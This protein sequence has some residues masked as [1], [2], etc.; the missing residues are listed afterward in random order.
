VILAR[1]EKLAMRGMAKTATNAKIATTAMNST[2]VKPCRLIQEKCN[3]T[4]L[5]AINHNSVHYQITNKKEDL[6]KAGLPFYVSL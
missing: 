4:N 5:N 3:I 6:R 1:Y 2:K